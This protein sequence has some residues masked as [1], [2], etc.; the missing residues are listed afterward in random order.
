M[1]S[2]GG[3]RAARVGVWRGP[4]VADE[5]RPTPGTH[6]GFRGVSGL[7]TEENEGSCRQELVLAGSALTCPLG[8]AKHLS[9]S[10]LPDL[11]TTLSLV[12]TPLPGVSSE[13]PV[14]SPSTY[15]LPASSSLSGP[16]RP[17]VPEHH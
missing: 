16:A 12:G 17:V 1:Q 13:F 5:V 6:G 14:S 4:L 8:S 7:R 3:S 10:S 9:P 2:S 11:L 15:S